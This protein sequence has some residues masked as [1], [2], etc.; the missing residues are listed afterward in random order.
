[1]K[2]KFLQNAHKLKNLEIRYNLIKQIDANIFAK[3]NNL[4]HINLEGNPIETIH[5]QAFN[6][7]PNLQGIYL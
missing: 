5:F 2:P 3:A 1:M 4:E 6:G 7:L